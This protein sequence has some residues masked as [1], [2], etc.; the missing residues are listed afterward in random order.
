MTES[1]TDR[2][3]L[4]RHPPF[5]LYAASRLF[6]VGAGG[7]LFV[8]VG[9]SLYELT[10]SK[11]Q[12]GLIGLAQFLPAFA[13]AF[14]SGAV[15]DR[16]DRRRIVM[17]CLV[18]SLVAATL[19]LSRP[20]SVGMIYAV[21]ALIGVT[22]AFSAPAGSALVAGL[23]PAHALQR[24]IAWQ[25][26]VFQGAMVGGPAVGGWL[27]DAFEGPEAVYAVAVGLYA[28]AL[29]GYVFIT[30]RA[31]PPRRRE[32]FLASLG[33]GLRY[34]RREKILLGA[35]S[36][37]LFA[38]LLGGATALLPVF[39]KD[40]LE[41][42][43]EV[44]GLLRGA[45][46]VGAGLAALLL[47]LRPMRRRVGSRMLVAVACFGAS[48]VLF[49]LSRT[50]PVAVLSLVLVGA[51]DMVS[52]VVRH[53]LIQSCTPDEMRGRVSAVSFVFISASNELGEFESGITAEWFGT[54]PAIV[55]GGAA[56]V[57]VVVLWAWLFPALRRA[58]RF[59]LP[60]SA[61]ASRE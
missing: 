12:L 7:M 15:A 49:G 45:P 6:M 39:A 51:T 30:V 59:E 46:A 8:A 53:T 40:V 54:V 1:G 38:A 58:D 2:F 10:G 33:A 26:A 21:A 23:V 11:L 55:L 47:A 61:R 28:L 57:G 50:I 16:F 25:M 36:L 31:M 19:L 42:G 52:V 3:S 41:Q 37:D 22:R 56:S 9:W 43:P 14:V 20:S 4:L 44:L 32:A 13:F 29:L 60:E 34:V 35:I 5:L 24:A 48:I 27:Y 17:G 18:A